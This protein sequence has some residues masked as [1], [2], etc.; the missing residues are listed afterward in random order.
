MLHGCFC[1]RSSSK[2]CLTQRYETR[3][4]RKLLFLRWLTRITCLA[5]AL[6]SK[7][8]VSKSYDGL[9]MFAFFNSRPDIID[10]AI[11]RPGRLDQLIYIPLPDERVSG[12]VRFSK[13]HRGLSFTR[14]DLNPL[15]LFCL[16]SV[17]CIHTKGLF[18]EI[19]YFKGESSLDGRDC[20]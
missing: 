8:Q 12:W 17:S 18:K 4:L 7:L 13:H 14:E 10:P 16:I 2:H 19:S 20:Y 9:K 15:T 1:A 5:L 6:R 3:C 11:L